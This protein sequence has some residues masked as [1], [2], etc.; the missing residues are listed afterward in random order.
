MCKPPKINIPPPPPPVDVEA[1]K[2]EL[3]ADLPDVDAAQLRKSKTAPVVQNR[4]LMKRRGLGISK[5][6]R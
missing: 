4:N 5:L 2:A 1:L 6:R 3:R